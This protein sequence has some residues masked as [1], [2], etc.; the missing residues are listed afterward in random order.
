[1]P[2]S[3]VVVLCQAW[4]CACEI[5]LPYSSLLQV[6][7]QNLRRTARDDPYLDVACSRCRHVFRYTPDVT[8]TRVFETRGPYQPPAQAAW[9]RVFLKCESEGCPS[10]LELES[11]MVSSATAMDINAFISGLV[12]DD[13]VKC[14]SGHQA[15]R[16]LE[17]MWAGILFP[18]WSTIYPL[19]SG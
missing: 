15:K 11:A 13:A 10:Y 3:L 6:R 5:V 14:C 17:I 9:S 8:R 18:I 4:G 12:L 1:M 16:P 19:R 7:Q 2:R